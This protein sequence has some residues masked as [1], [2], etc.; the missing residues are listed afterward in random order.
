M[1]KY[2][3]NENYVYKFHSFD[4]NLFKILLNQELWFGK[5]AIQNDPFEGEFI[6]EGFE[7]EPTIEELKK[8]YRIINPR[9]SKEFL[10]K[11][12]DHIPD[13]YT[14][15]QNYSDFLK[16]EIKDKFGICSFSK[17]YNNIL[18]WSHYAD[19]HSGVCLIFDKD[20][21]VPSIKENDNEI[22]YNEVIPQNI[23]PKVKIRITDNG[24]PFV[25]NY[26]VLLSKFED[27]K[28]EDEVRFVK[29]FNPMFNEDD[30][31]NLKFDISALKGIIIGEGMTTENMRSIYQLLN[32]HL[33]LKHISIFFAQKNI[34]EGKVDAVVYN[35]QHPRYDEIHGI[36][37]I[38][39]GGVIKE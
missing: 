12:E 24:Y 33:N 6:I 17:S 36:K 9:Y 20:I 30:K 31:R 25:N 5:P 37:Y 14:L 8:M 11:I 13:Q 4:A 35:E 10:D 34:Y 19:S 32:G 28:Y 22:E 1:I 16:K 38:H 27:F 39:L 26:N 29:F 3:D 18:L 21:L 2:P 7:K 15:I 23:A